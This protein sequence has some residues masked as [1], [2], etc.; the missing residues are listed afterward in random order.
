MQQC[1]KCG[2]LID[3]LSDEYCTTKHYLRLKNW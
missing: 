2:K 3:K 1:E